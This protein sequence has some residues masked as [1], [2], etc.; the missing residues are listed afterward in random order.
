MLQAVLKS[1]AS[2]NH[3]LVLVSSYGEVV[4]AIATMCSDLGLAMWSG[5]GE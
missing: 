3:Q 2:E 1:V 5:V 4:Q